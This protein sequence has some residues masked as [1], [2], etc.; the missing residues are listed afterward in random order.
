[1]WFIVVIIG[2]S[3]ICTV[4]KA[5]AEA[6]IDRIARDGRIAAKSCARILTMHFYIVSVIIVHHAHVQMKDAKKSHD[7]CKYDTPIQATPAS[8]VVMMVWRWWRT[9]KR[10][11]WRLWWRL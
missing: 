2:K 4:R 5:R 7:D 11:S 10:M 1:M 3:K 9:P 6:S 8:G